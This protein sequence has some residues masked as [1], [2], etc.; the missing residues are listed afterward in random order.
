[1][2]WK[3]ISKV[4]RGVRQDRSIL[5]FGRKQLFRPWLCF[6]LNFK[7]EREGGG[8]GVEDS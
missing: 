3:S 4:N 8:D 6:R 1:M 7:R 2:G 5:R